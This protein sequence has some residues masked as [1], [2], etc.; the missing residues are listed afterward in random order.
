MSQRLPVLKPKEVVRV[1]EK[2]GYHQHRQTGSH[3]IMI[4]DNSSIQ[5]IVPIHNRDLKKGTLRAIIREAG[6]TVE[7]F[8][9]YL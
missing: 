5:P 1:L 7:E 2:L 9:N 4:K 3:L 8:C 6:C